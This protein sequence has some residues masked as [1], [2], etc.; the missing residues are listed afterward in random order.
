MSP[1][2]SA[3]ARERPGFYFFICPDI[4]L[5]KRR[6]RELLASN[7][8]VSSAVSGSLSGVSSP[9]GG[10]EIRVFWAE[11]GLIDQ[12]WQVLTLNDLFAKPKALVVRNVQELTTEQ[13]KQLA[14]PLSRFNP[15]AWPLFFWERPLDRGKSLPKYLTD[16]KFWQFAEKRGWIWRSPGLGQKGVEDWV[17]AWA[18]EKGL[19][20]APDGLQALLTGLPPDAAALENELAKLELAVPTGGVIDAGLAELL[21]STPDIDIFAFINALQG[22][23]A[24]LTVWRK[25]L[26]SQLG[27][28]GMLFQFLVMLVREARIFWQ[29]VHQEQTPRLPPSVLDAKRQMAQRMGA[30]RIGRIWTAAMEA[31]LRVKTGQAGEEQALELL[32]ADLEAVFRPQS[33][34]PGGVSPPRQGTRP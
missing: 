13:W 15:L 26:M 11:E 19:R 25:V 1:S 12:F 30:A 18:R 31:E 7:A 6:M 3:A 34:S 16:T 29:L 5:S 10:F 14:A 4:E 23:R 24:A 33:R 32:I 22:G 2:P 9:G 17:R 8:P 21:T 20:L 27:S 28:T